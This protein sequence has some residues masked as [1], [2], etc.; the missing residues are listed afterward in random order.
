MK[1]KKITIFVEVFFL[2]KGETGCDRTG[3]EEWSLVSGVR[4]T[5]WTLFLLLRFW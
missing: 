1:K 5:Q 3:P 2:Q 4:E